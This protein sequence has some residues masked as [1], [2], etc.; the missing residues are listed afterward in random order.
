MDLVLSGHVHDYAR[1]CNVLDETCVDERDGGMSHITI[2]TAGH[3][4]SMVEREQAA[5][6]KHAE[7]TYGYGRLAVHGSERLQFEFV[8]TEDGAVLDTMELVNARVAARN[9]P[10]D[11]GGGAV[12]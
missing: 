1:T 11:G 6:L 12:V 7:M 2:G 4:L 3:K 5:W 10:R 9:C 8:A